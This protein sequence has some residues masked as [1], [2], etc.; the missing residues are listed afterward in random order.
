MRVMNHNWSA[1]KQ[2]LH[3]Q[4]VAEISR[5]SLY[6]LKIAHRR[7]MENNTN[8]HFVAFDVGLKC[9]C[10]ENYRI[11]SIVSGKLQCEACPV[12]QVRQICS[13]GSIKYPKWFCKQSCG[14]NLW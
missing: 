3:L 12:G 6:G 13:V 8:C 2:C 4:S 1:T 9:V 10:R 5:H 11:A 7:Q 14:F